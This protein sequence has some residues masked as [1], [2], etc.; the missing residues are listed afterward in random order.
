M[1]DAELDGLLSRTLNQVQILH[2]VMA[3][4]LT[5]AADPTAV[6]SSVLG[7]ESG[8]Y[9]DKLFAIHAEVRHAKQALKLKA[10]RPAQRRDGDERGFQAIGAML[11]TKL[12]PEQEVAAHEAVREQR[13]LQTS[14][15]GHNELAA[16]AEL[17]LRAQ[18]AAA[19]S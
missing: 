14:V 10:P 3:H 17:Y 12:E 5:D 7:K 8:A 1:T 6:L 15:Q 16:A 13:R 11:G 19:T 4:G 9:A 18:I 2:D